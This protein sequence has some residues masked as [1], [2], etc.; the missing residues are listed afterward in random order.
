MLIQKST[1]IQI[2]DLRDYLLMRKHR[3]DILEHL[4]RKNHWTP[5]AIAQVDW[6][7]LDQ[8]L[9]KAGI[10]KRIKLHNELLYLVAFPLLVNSKNVANMKIKKALYFFFLIKPPR[11]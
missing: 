3:H 4:S 1:N 11:Y 10:L 8:C 5:E 6:A 9:K 7:G 2:T